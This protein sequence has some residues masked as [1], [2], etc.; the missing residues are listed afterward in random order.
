MDCNDNSAVFAHC[1]PSALLPLFLDGNTSL[2]SLFLTYQEDL[3]PLFLF[4][5]FFSFLFFSFLSFF[6]FHS[7]STVGTTL[8]LFQPPHKS[9]QS[10]LKLFSSLTVETTPHPHHIH[11]LHLLFSSSNFWQDCPS[12]SSTLFTLL[13]QT[14]LSFTA[15]ISS[16]FK[17]EWSQM[18]HFIWITAANDM[19]LI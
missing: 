4:F 17:L 13:V 11:H 14:G 18:S 9:A 19:M 1:F 6:S 7:S 5:F 3:L 8:S 2:S 12:V 10:P 16:S 15:N